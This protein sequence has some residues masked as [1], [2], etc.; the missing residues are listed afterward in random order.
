MSPGASPVFAS[1]RS[2]NAAAENKMHGILLPEIK[3]INQ[4][5]TLLLPSLPFRSGSLSTLT[6]GVDEE[7]IRLTRQIEN[8]GSFAQFHFTPAMDK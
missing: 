7:Q 2:K 5:A 1:I 6:R 8:T 3:A 4:Q